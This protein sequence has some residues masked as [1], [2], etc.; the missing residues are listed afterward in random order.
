MMSQSEVF[1]VLADSSLF[2]SFG[3]PEGFGL[4]VAEAMSLAVWLLDIRA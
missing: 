3:H 4:P 1:S 2:L